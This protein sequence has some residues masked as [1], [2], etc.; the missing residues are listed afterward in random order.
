MNRL[1]TSAFLIFFAYSGHLFAAET[2]TCIHTFYQ[3]GTQYQYSGTTVDSFK[4][5]TSMQLYGVQYGDGTG[6]FVV[7]DA[8][9]TKTNSPTTAL[10]LYHAK[11]AVL[12]ARWE[13]ISP[14]T[15]T[16][17]RTLTGVV[18]QGATY[19]TGAGTFSS[20][21]ATAALPGCPAANPCEEQQGQPGAFMYVGLPYDSQTYSETGICDNGCVAKP[22]AGVTSDTYADDG[23]GYIIGP[24]TYTGDQCEAGVTSDLPPQPP[25][26]QID[27][28]ADKVC[29]AK[30][31]GRSYQYDPA[32]GQCEC[33]GAPGVIEPPLEPTEPTTDPGSPPVPGAQTPATDPGGDPQLGAQIA[34]Q[35]KQIG[36]GD[37]QLGQLG[38]INN[39][40]GAVISNQGKQIGQADKGL[41]YQRRQL[42]ALE[43]IKNEM[44]KDDNAD[45]PNLPDQPELDGSI[46]DTKNWTEH[47]DAEAVGQAQGQKQIDIIE[48]YQSDSPFTFGINTSGADPCLSGPMLGTQ[49]DICFN[50]P[51]MLTGYAIMN[52]ITISVG[53]LQA[54]LMIQKVVTGA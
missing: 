22:S 51:W 7:A 54:F 48:D 28:A 6:N 32:T 37:A 12:N 26:E 16:Q 31:A 43:D 36:Q 50:R 8:S 14:S 9:S 23:S 47:D 33:F 49:I 29:A 10:Y 42:D 25:Q 4:S 1:F 39:K 41:D 52:G 53:Y 34:N 27:D 30:C 40:L 21:A 5:V 15:G 20:P 24:W 13:S 35:G 38:A 45:V 44:A 2:Y 19:I 11:W 46:P 17:T 18:P 3:L